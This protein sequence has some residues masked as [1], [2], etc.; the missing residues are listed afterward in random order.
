MI[1]LTVVGLCL[2]EAPRGLGASQ[3]T[4]PGSLSGSNGR[5]NQ[6]DLSVLILKN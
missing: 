6:G 1:A 3:P 4:R 2:S 5:V